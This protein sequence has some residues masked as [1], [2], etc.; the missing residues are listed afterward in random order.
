MPQIPMAMAAVREEVAVLLLADVDAAATAA[1]DDPGPRR[2]HAEPGIVPGFAAGDHAEERG[3]RVA[4]RV[5]ARLPAL[6][7]LAVEGE[8]GSHVHGRHGRR[9]LRRVARH[10]ELR[11]GAR[12]A[13][14]A[15]DMVPET[16]TA[17]A[18]R[19]D[20]ADAGDDDARCAHG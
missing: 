19:R 4:L 11:D 2:A 5:G 12:A 14:A 6:R 13:H 1:D 15:R 7:G 18:E 20:D 16:L 3:A 10:I 17:D 8:R 9:D